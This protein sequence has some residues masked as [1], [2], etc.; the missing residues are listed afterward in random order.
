MKFDPND[1]SMSARDKAFARFSVEGKN[2]VVTGGARGLGLACVYA[3]FEHGATGALLLDINEPALEKTKEA[4][5]KVFP[6]RKV[7]TKVVDVTDPK[8][9]KQ[10]VEYAVANLASIDILL[11]FAGVGELTGPD[12][13]DIENSWIH[14]WERILKVNLSGVYYTSILFGEQMSENENGGAIV[15]V[16]SLVGH[17]GSGAIPHAYAASK[18]AILN[19]RTTLADMYRGNSIRV[20][21]ISPGFIDTDMTAPL[22]DAV[23]DIFSQITPIPRFGKVDEIT[24]AVVLLA[25]DA[26]S[27]MTGADILIDGGALNSYM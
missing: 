14:S 16:A 11:P 2:V 26:G 22:P 18:A 25:S 27:Y 10:A 24:G 4:L 1:T 15:M 17:Q 23:R 7:L 3:L 9:I 12:D 5:G 19:L 20:N 6:D 13:D 8:S 21:S